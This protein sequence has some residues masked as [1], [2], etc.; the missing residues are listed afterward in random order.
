[1]PKILEITELGN[2][3]LRDNAMPVENIDDPIIQELIEDMILTVKET[4]GVGLAAPQVSVPLR[5]FVMASYPNKRYPDA[6]EMVPTVVI[7]PEIIDKSNDTIKDW[8]G[9]LSIPGIR[10]LVPRNQ[11]VE[12]KYYNRHGMLLHETL[13]DF[14]ARVF[15]HENDHLNG[16]VFL[17]I[18]ENTQDI[19]TESEYIKLFENE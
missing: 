8:E 18:L 14:I 19:I 11:S 7:N 13:N 3:V 9:C 6:P 15:Q 5:I 4:H 10:A 2:P 12:V 17:D 1:M 16:I